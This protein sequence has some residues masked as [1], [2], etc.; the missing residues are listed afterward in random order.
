MDASKSLQLDRMVDNSDWE[1]F[2]LLAAKFEANQ[3]DQKYVY[4]NNIMQKSTTTSS[5]KSATD[6]SILS[7]SAS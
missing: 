5:G 7:N 3:D 1:D 2:V 4:S 6:L